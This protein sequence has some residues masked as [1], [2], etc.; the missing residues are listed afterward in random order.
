MA[1]KFGGIGEI[2]GRKGKGT[3]EKWRMG[4]RNGDVGEGWR[5]L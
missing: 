3:V 5:V 1:G 2:G 4:C